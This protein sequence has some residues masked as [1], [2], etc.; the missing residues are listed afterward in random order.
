MVKHNQKGKVRKMAEKKLIT[1]KLLEVQ[2]ALKAPKSQTNAF[3][4]YKYRS[5]EDILEAVKP[6]LKK[7][8]LTLGLSD[9]IVLIGERYY[10]RATAKIA[11]GESVMEVT[12][13]AR[14][15]QEK[16][17]MDAAQVSGATSSYSRKYALNGLFLIDDTK[18]ADT[19]DNSEEG[20]HGTA[21][22]RSV[23]AKTQKPQTAKPA[24]AP[25]A[26]GKKPDLKSNSML[27]KRAAEISKTFQLA[28]TVEQ[29][30]GLAAEFKAEIGIMPEKFQTW[31]RDEYTSNKTAIERRAETED[32]GEEL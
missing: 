18:D 28:T 5:C 4:K 25:I 8:G 30:K 15:P 21:A 31:L 3:G 26:K 29:I 23:G 12:A 1:E 27:E 7:N 14:E 16:K 9:E 11:D 6:L 19:M 2:A 22:Q 13:F 17:G 20:S 24:P 10:V 32:G